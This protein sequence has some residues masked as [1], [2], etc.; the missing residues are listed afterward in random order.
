MVWTDPVT[1]G[2]RARCAALAEL[3]GVPVVSVHAPTL[4]LTQR[5]WGTDPWAKVDR[6]L[7]AGRAT[8]GADTVV[9][10]PPFR[11]QRD[12]AAG[13]VDGVALREHDSGIALAVENMF[14]WRARSREMLG[15]PAALGP[16][17]PALRPRHARPVAHRDR[18]VGRDGDG[19]GARATGCGTCTWPT[20]A[21]RPRTSTWCPGRGAQPCAELLETLAQQSCDGTVVVEVGTR[22]RSA[23]ASARPTSPRRSPSPGC[24]SP[25][26]RHEPA[27]AAW[28]L[29]MS[30]RGRRP[31]G[32]DTRQPIVDAARAEFAD[33]GYDATSLRGIARRAG[34][35][36]A[37]VHHYFD[38]KAQ[39]FAAAHGAAVP[40]GGRDRRGARAAPRRG[41]GAPGRRPSSRCGTVP[42]E[43]GAVRGLCARRSATR[44]RPGC[45]ASS[46]P[47]RSSAASPRELRRRRT[48]E[49]RAG[50]AAAQMVGVAMLR[51][52][53]G[54]EP[55]VAAD[56]ATS[57]PPCVAP[58]LQRYLVDPDRADSFAGAPDPCR[59][60]GRAGLHIHHMMNQWDVP[61][62]VRAACGRRCAAGARCCRTSRW[63][64]PRGPGR[65]AARAERR[66]QVDP[67][68]GRRRGAG[69]RR[70][71]TVTV[72]GRAG[73]VAV[74]ARAGSAT[75]PRPRASTA[76]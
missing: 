60:S 68:A 8:S 41:R 14:P 22:R 47:G 52:V 28:G 25:R 64:C 56:P 16:G 9:L 19:R 74:A 13:F 2:G 32:E 58:T 72:L 61:S 5:V 73:R 55:L 65:R 70:A 71:A 20:A 24:T 50:L 45:C 27:R 15:L 21:A 43:P 29:R 54:F 66:R 37:L 11:W 53:V 3:H 33:Q 31:G 30:P 10:H 4:L 6:S 35:D 1:P 12:Y 38:G 39:L 67:D 76:T 18:R 44:R 75:S 26:H 49:L 59:A 62:T 7:R 36:P 48:H 57:W 63:R 23:G 17:R 69:R 34:V 42:D 51:Y 46:S 40:P